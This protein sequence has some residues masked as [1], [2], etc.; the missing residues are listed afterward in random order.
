M[1]LKDKI[2]NAKARLIEFSLE[3]NIIN[4]HDNYTK[5]II[6]GMGRTGSNFLVS[7]LQS[8]KNIITF[9]EIFNNAHHEHIYWKQ[10]GYRKSNIA[11]EMRENLPQEFISSMVFRKMPKWISAVGFKL[12]YYHGKEEQWECIWPF[13]KDMQNLKIIHL[14]RKN[15][16]E[17]FL[18]MNYAMKD[19]QWLIKSKKDANTKQAIELGYD[20][21]LKGFK[22]IRE[23]EKENDN[24]FS[25]QS[26]LEVFYEDL[27]G[28]Y[29]HEMS[30]IQ[31]F[32]EIP[33][34]RT[35]AS[36]KKQS[37]KKLSESISN[38]AELKEH[39]IGS[40]WASFFEE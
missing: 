9:G 25:K 27:A 4:G 10:P 32:L 19:R 12:F 3:N 5:F 35:H 1:S 37:N 34:A 38:Y 7:S 14:K 13:L 28:N 2:K 15:L 21:T 11:L 20:E 24:Y 26:L 16:L 23:W 17:T 31:Q 40:E 30:R 6:L 22:Q 29:E 39:F 8:Q 36:T 18:S 33:H